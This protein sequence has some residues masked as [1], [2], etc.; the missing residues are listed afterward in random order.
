STAISQGYNP[1][2]VKGLM[3]SGLSGTEA[4]FV[5]SQMPKFG[6]IN[7]KADASSE[8][9]L[10]QQQHLD[11]RQ[12]L[13]N[14]IAGNQLI[15]IKNVKGINSDAPQTL[16]LTYDQ[17]NKLKD[18]IERNDLNEFK[19]IVNQFISGSA[20]DVG[21]V[22][23][24]LRGGLT[25][26][27]R[28]VSNAFGKMWTGEWGNAQYQELMN[29][30]KSHF[31]S[32]HVQNQINRID[33]ATKAV[34]DSVSAGVPLEEAL[35]KSGLTTQLI[36]TNSQQFQTLLQ[37]F[38]NT[39]PQSQQELANIARQYGI[40]LSGEQTTPTA[41]PPQTTQQQGTTPNAT[42]QQQ[43][44]TPNAAA[45]ASQPAQTTTQATATNTQDLYSQ[46]R[47]SVMNRFG[48]SNPTSNA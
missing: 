27:G 6:A 33:A 32:K 8:Q 38:H 37:T 46:F 30:L 35:K 19:N 39:K 42:A 22:G 2:L 47:T 40:Q 25:A 36:P 20:Q 31:Q 11:A 14:A 45:Q 12:Q 21:Y 17:Y 16:H 7:K 23:G 43:G 5:A 28:L 3:D 9:Y 48:F 18:A 26:L 29:E 44:T 4:L 24:G 13:H 41:T 1:L 10:Q 34:I 15:Y